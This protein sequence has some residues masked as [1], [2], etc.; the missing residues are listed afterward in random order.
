MSASLRKRHSLIAVH[1]VRAVR[2][3]QIM[4]ARTKAAVLAAFIVKSSVQH[5]SR[6]AASDI[7]CYA[8]DS[9]DRIANNHGIYVNRVLNIHI[10]DIT[11]ELPCFVHPLFFCLLAAAICRTNKIFVYFACISRI[12]RP[13][14]LYIQIARNTVDINVFFRLIDT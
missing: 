1:L 12:T 9:I 8:A 6:V 10:K 2:K 14:K 5:A 11:D 7:N 13:A 4:P 3:C